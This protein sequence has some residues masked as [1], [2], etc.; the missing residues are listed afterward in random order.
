M[1]SFLRR[2]HDRRYARFDKAARV[3]FDG[4]SRGHRPQVLLDDA[5][6]DGD[7]VVALPVFNQRQGVQRVHYVLLLYRRELRDVFDGQIPAVLLQQ[8]Q[9]HARPVAPVADLRYGVRNYAVR[10]GAACKDDVDIH[11][12]TAAEPQDIACH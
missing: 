5:R 6:R 7:D 12:P 4:V 1:G 11:S 2:S 3:H 8:L 10:P 9:H